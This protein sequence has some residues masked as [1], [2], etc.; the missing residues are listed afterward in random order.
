LK[1]GAVPTIATPSGCPQ[2]LQ[3]TRTTNT[4]GSSLKSTIPSEEN[5]FAQ[6]RQDFCWKYSWIAWNP[7]PWYL[8]ITDHRSS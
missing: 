7:P 3:L 4:P 2:D 1:R 5:G 8:P 6:K